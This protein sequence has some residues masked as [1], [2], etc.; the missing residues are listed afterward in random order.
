MKISFWGTPYISAALLKQL[1]SH[2]R[3]KVEY[4]VT[5]K[6]KPRSVRGREIQPSP[7]KKTALDSGIQILEPDS[8]KKQKDEIFSYMNLHP[9]DCHV[10]LAYGKII[11]RE[12]Y[13]N[14]NLG[15]VNFHASLLPDLR[16]ASP[17]ESALINGN[18]KT[19]W[20]LQK[21][22]SDLDAGDILKTVSLSIEYN[23]TKDLLYQKM[24]ELLLQFAADALL[25]FERGLLQ[26]EKQDHQK[27]NYCGKI[28]S[29]TG[30]LN[31]NEPAEKIRNLARALHE[32][33]GVYT[34]WN[35]KKIKLFIDF[36]SDIIPDSHSK[37]GEIVKIDSLLWIKATGGLLPVSHLQLDGKKKTDILSF[38]N[39]NPLKIGQLFQSP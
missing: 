12:L 39:G 37:C 5:Q 11:P 9:V 34:G 29:E 14:A 18:S 25:D 32:R 6:D 26:P 8:L 27:A 36:S 31:F 30:K 2:S 38:L 20:T 21:I 3:F 19:G 23:D 15:A 35:G 13:E 33:P 22:N 1:L 16:G 28:H 17:V 7:V 10:I 24:T 4:V